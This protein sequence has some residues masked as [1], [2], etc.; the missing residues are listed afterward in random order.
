M[1]NAGGNKNKSS[2]QTLSTIK[3]YYPAGNK[4]EI[5]TLRTTEEKKMADDMGAVMESSPILIKEAFR[6]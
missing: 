6:I 1:R 2:T 5:K 3:V 4:Q